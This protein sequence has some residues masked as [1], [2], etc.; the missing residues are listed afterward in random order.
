MYNIKKE[1]KGKLG[2]NKII[3]KV[4]TDKNSKSYGRLGFSEFPDPEPKNELLKQAEISERLDNEIAKY[5]RYITT[6]NYGFYE[7][8]SKKPKTLIK[9]E[10][11]LY[12]KYGKKIEVVIGAL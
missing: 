4:V 7:S 5:V 9:L 3:A 12:I 2:L 1:N 11:L 6:N 10:Q 8:P